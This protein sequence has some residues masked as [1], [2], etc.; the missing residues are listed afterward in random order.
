MPTPADRS[1]ARAN[2]PADTTNPARPV[3][4][5]A[6]RSLAAPGTRDA[7]RGRTRRATIRSRLV[8]CSP[9]T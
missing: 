8:A 7:R 1:R 9:P 4:C 6:R 5:P 2:A 3:L